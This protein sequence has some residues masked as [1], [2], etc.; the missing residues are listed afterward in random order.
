MSIKVRVCVGV[1]V[2]AGDDANSHIIVHDYVK[3]L[4]NAHAHVHRWPT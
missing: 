1:G 4:V 2:G 3:T